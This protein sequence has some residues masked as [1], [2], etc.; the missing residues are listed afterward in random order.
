M[1]PARPL[2]PQQATFKHRY[3][4]KENPVRDNGASRVV[5]EIQCAETRLSI[6]Q[7][8]PPKS[9]TLTHPTQCC[10]QRRNAGQRFSVLP[11][12]RGLDYV[13]VGLRVYFLLL[14]VPPKGCR[15]NVPLDQTPEYTLTALPPCPSWWD[16]LSLKFPDRGDKARQ[17]YI[18]IQKDFG[19][20]G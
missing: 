12:R 14:L 11:I 18:F 13:N 15:G 16:H 2:M 8:S 10:E 4:R 17:R 1:S 3:K 20:V 7:N 6:Y 19:T 9:L 5:E